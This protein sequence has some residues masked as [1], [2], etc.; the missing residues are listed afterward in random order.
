MSKLI[1]TGT[2][3][4]HAHHHGSVN[5]QVTS[6]L[7]SALLVKY[8]DDNDLIDS[9]LINMQENMLIFHWIY[10][11]TTSICDCSNTVQWAEYKYFPPTFDETNCETGRDCFFVFSYCYEYCSMPEAQRAA[12]GFTYNIESN[13]LDNF[14]LF[15]V[16]GQF[17]PSID[18]LTVNRYRRLRFLN[19]ISEYYIQYNFPTAN[20]EWSVIAIDGIF[21]RNNEVRNINNAP[22][23]GEYLLPPG[24]RLDVIV[25]CS[26]TGTYTITSSENNA[27]DPDL[28]NIGRVPTGITLFEIQV[29]SAGSD[30]VTTAPNQY[31]PKPNY[32]TDLLTATTNICGCNTYFPTVSRAV[33][34][35]EQECGYVFNT[36]GN[37]N[38]NGIVFDQNVM[39]VKFI[40]FSK[41]SEKHSIQIQKYY[42]NNIL[43]DYS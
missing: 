36:Q 38:I 10:V 27:I 25:I 21:L 31:P 13:H 22:Y 2:H 43:S 37:H 1:S 9:S 11:I 3:W 41:A 32:L 39:T 12:S 8:S 34:W 33:T 23:N 7:F 35:T 26:A 5:F 30:T 16:N 14:Q 18:D 24:G 19:A 15:L 40:R 42:D 28:F 29:N 6:G 17:Q 4:L 20:C